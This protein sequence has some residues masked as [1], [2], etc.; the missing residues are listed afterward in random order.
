MTTGIETHYQTLG[1]ARDAKSHD[2]VRAYKRLK[3]QLEKDSAAPDP[4]R[5]RRVEAAFAVLND[6][7]QREAYDASI[8]QTRR[9]RAGSKTAAWVATIVIGVAAIVWYVVEVRAP[10]SKPVAGGMSQ[11][12]I[13]YAAS[14]AVGRL[15]A[16]DIGGQAKDL[17]VAFAAAEGV[18][19]A[20]CRGI[21]PS[22][23]LVVSIPP[24]SLP[25]RVASVDEKLGLCKLAALGTG[26]RPLPLAGVDPKSGD[27]LFAANVGGTGKVALAEAYV[28]KVDPEERLIDA[29]LRESAVASGSPLIDAYG[30]VVGLA[31][32]PAAD[33]KPR[34]V[35]LPKAWIRE[36]NEPPPPEQKTQASGEEAAPAKP[37]EQQELEPQAPAI[38]LSPEHQKRLE[39]TYRP[40]PK[41]PDDL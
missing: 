11:D 37:A 7:A 18:M 40:P 28:R 26:T 13:L 3:S 2:I 30:R 15:Q 33:G 9:K 25:A 5:L 21:T 34:H 35:A 6:P 12:E 29:S 41:L 10:Q 16:L 23:Q 14:V 20:P 27:R 4:K 24:R 32:V 39:K 1:V 36:I 31:F 17:G 22:A 19:V 8:T 38:K